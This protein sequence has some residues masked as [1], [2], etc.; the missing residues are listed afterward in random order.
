MY[1]SKENKSQNSTHA[2]HSDP[3][4]NNFFLTDHL[5]ELIK[6]GILKRP[7]NTLSRNDC[8]VEPSNGRAPQ[9]RTY[10]TTPSDCEQKETAE[11]ERVR[12]CETQDYKYI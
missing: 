6:N 9:T 10:N 3:T 1:Y 2:K 7:D 8:S 11:E 12:E 4:F 5:P